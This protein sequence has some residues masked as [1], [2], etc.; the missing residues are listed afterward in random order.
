MKRVNIY[1]ANTND[2]I[3]YLNLVDEPN[4]RIKSNEYIAFG[5]IKNN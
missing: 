2:Y 5:N 3:A 4:G 1:D